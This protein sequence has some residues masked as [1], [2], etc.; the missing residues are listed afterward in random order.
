MMMILSFVASA[1]DV[2][3]LSDECSSNLVVARV[4]NDLKSKLSH[5]GLL[6]NK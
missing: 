4:I 1:L 6:Q 3:H 2:S 5:F